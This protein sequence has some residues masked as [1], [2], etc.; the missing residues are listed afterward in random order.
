MVRSL[1]SYRGFVRASVTR[2]MRLRY[3]GSALGALWQV[4][5]PLAMIA[6]Y[7][8]VFSSLMRARLPGIDDAYGY[9]IYVCSGLLAWNM[10]S[11]ILLRSQT[12]FIENANLLKKASFPRTCIPAIVV[13]GSLAN[14]AIVY[15]VFLAVLAAAG[16]WPG[17]AIV[18]MIVPIALLAVLGLAVGVCLGIL[19]VFFRDVG[20]VF[21]IVLQVWF[22]LTPI[23]YPLHV[24][25]DEFAAWIAANPLTP[26]MQALQ[27]IFLEHTWP[28]WQAL[29]Y[30]AVL[31]SALALA[32][33]VAF[34]HQ[35][36]WIV[37][38]L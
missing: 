30:P 26:I 16:R 9:T 3:A 13:T 11:E 5:S 34:R 8:I 31:A 12:M 29:A 15:G 23:V 17:V 1:W 33:A 4:L 2:E 24:I 19:H 7:T 22:W 18:A 32:S 38:E 6:I 14:A 28:P 36:P 20:Q 27:A 10:F 37:D 35:S 21:G 25:P